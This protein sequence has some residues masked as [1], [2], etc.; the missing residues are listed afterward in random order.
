MVQDPLDLLG[1]NFLTS[2][3]E[4]ENR[5]V[6]VARSRRH[7]QPFQ[8]RQ[9]HRS[10]DRSAFADS[11]GRATRSQMQRNQVEPLLI[12]THQGG[13]SLKHPGVANP[14]KTEATDT[15]SC[16]QRSWNRII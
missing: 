14:M 11:G 2:R 16:R 15:M 5:W 13:A 7:H 9:S 3:K 12:D 4:A 10:V 1:G 8:W 6:D